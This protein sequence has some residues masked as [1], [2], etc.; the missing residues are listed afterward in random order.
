MKRK[1]YQKKKKLKT[2]KRSKGRESVSPWCTLEASLYEEMSAVL[3]LALL[4]PIIIKYY[5]DGDGNQFHKTRKNTK[6]INSGNKEA[7]PR[8]LVKML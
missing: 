5:V 1:R 6:Y 8:N 2:E 7:M 4:S 3:Q